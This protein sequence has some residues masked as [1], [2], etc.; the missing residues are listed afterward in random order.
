MANITPRHY[1]YGVIIMMFFITGGMGLLGILQ[2]TDAGFDVNDRT[3]EFNRT[4]NKLDS[5]TTQVDN[6]EDSFDTDPEWGVFGA[7][8]ALIK[9][10]WNTFALMFTSWAFMDTVFNG[11]YTVFGV[12]LWVATFIGLFITVSL[13]FAIYSLIFQKDS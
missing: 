10:A 5:V 13:A 1:I 7:L 8:N 11:L 9:G 12:P 3:G 4:F 2:S 6:I